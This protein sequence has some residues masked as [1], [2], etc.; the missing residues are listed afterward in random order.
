MHSFEQAVLAGVSEA[1]P[2]LQEAQ[3]KLKDIIDDET[4]WNAKINAVR[5][6]LMTS[7]MTSDIERDIKEADKTGKYSLYLKHCIKGVRPDASPREKEL[8][9][10]AARKCN[11][12]I[13]RLV[14]EKHFDDDNIGTLYSQRR[15]NIRMAESGIVEFMGR[16]AD[17]YRDGYDK[18]KQN[19]VL[20]REW[21]RIAAEHGD[22]HS[23]LYYGIFCKEGYGGDIDYSNAVKYLNEA[24][25]GHYNLE[26]GRAFYNLALLVGNGL[27]IDKNKETA[28]LLLEAAQK[29]GWSPEIETAF[30]QGCVV[31]EKQQVLA[32]ELHIEAHIYR[33]DN[34]NY[35]YCLPPLI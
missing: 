10:E 35:G 34:E 11:A 30:Q 8:I 15:M 1:E 23:Q 17:A 9:C 31:A 19:L 25:K 32:E 5:E 7:G 6:S 22:Q 4:Q 16:G 18:V 27:G 33:G 26:A 2:L 14:E 20:A 13:D 28:S 12:L 21:Y 24:G 29:L 3:Q